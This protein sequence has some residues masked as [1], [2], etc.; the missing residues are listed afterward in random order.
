MTESTPRRQ[1]SGTL[2]CFFCNFSFKQRKVNRSPLVKGFEPLRRRKSKTFSLSPAGLQSWI[3]GI[4]NRTEAPRAK[5]K[6][7]ARCKPPKNRVTSE[8]APPLSA[9]GLCARRAS[10]QSLPGFRDKIHSSPAVERHARLLLFWNFFLSKKKK[11]HRF[12][13]GKGIRTAP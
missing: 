1:S 3:G 12:P 11:V 6:S 4:R 2:V 9:R 13:L 7:T 10:S 5:R 8:S